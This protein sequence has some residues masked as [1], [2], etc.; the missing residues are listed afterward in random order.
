MRFPTAMYSDILQVSYSYNWVR[1]PEAVY[2][3]LPLTS[4]CGM[5]YNY[6]KTYHNVEYRFKLYGGQSEDTMEGNDIGSYKIKLDHMIGANLHILVD[7]F[8]IR[9]GY[10][11][12]DITIDSTVINY[13]F[14]HALQ[15]P[16]LTP[17]EISLLRQ[18]D[19]QEKM[20]Q[21]FSLGFKYE[22]QELY[23]LGEYILIN[24]NNIISDNYAGYLS[25]GY[26]LGAFTPHIT[27]AKVTGTSNY[28]GEFKDPILNARLTEMANRTLNAQENITLGVRYDW[29]ENIALK[30]QYDHIREQD[31]GRGLSI[32]DES[33]RIPDTI[34]LFSFSMDFIF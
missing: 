13:Y 30:V 32:H 27:Y 7:D 31:E 9:L 22:Q 15:N 17:K 5:E 3:I 2:G 18:Y 21:Y 6:Q 19:P 29:K 33:P 10:T 28:H 8:E 4:Y 20:T 16:K 23:L 11:R 14:N 12:T 1:L 26:H 25:L 34:H 24:L